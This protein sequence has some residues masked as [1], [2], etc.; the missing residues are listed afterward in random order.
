M[1]SAVPYTDLFSEFL[2]LMVAHPSEPLALAVVRRTVRDFCARTRAWQEDTDPVD[3]VAGQALYDLDL[4]PGSNVVAVLGVRI[5]DQELD[6]IGRAMVRR[7]SAGKWSAAGTPSWF[8]HEDN[9]GQIRLMPAPTATALGALVMSV[10]LQPSRNSTSFPGHIADRYG[11]A[12]AAGAGAALLLMPKRDWTDQ[13]TG[14]DLRERYEAAL[15]NAIGHAATKPG[16]LRTV[17]IN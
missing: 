7:G 11:D 4:P 16:V 9:D 12:I 14:V 8:S 6:P 17:S 10:A 13:N 1:A 5:G 15:A 3:V 2:P